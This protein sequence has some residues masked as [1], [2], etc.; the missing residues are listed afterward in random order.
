MDAPLWTEAHAPALDELP[1]AEFR[2][3]LE[4]AG[5]PDEGDDHGAL[6]PV[7]GRGGEE[8]LEDEPHEDE[9]PGHA[10]V[11]EE[12]EE[13]QRAAAGG[14][15]HRLPWPTPRAPLNASVR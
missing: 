2:D 5:D 12:V 9:D 1:Q 3:R 15:G 10:A 4:R 7:C 14:D 13:R 11:E 6:V 8:P